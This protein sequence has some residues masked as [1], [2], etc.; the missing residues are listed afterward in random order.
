MMK[1]AIWNASEWMFHFVTSHR[2]RSAMPIELLTQQVAR[3]LINHGETAPSLNSK[4]G[5]RPDDLL[6]FEFHDCQ[7][8][9]AV[10]AHEVEVTFK[11]SVIRQETGASK[12]LPRT[13]DTSFPRV[14]PYTIS[15]VDL[16]LRRPPLIEH[17]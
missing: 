14:F 1:R 7:S 6:D 12:H 8:Q 11:M 5:H 3:L 15:R 9:A 16:E 4:H 10:H 17:V 2:N 13:T